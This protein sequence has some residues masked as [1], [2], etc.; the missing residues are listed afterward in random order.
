MRSGQYKVSGVG[1]RSTGT[2]AVINQFRTTHQEL[3][4]TNSGSDYPHMNSLV[5]TMNKMA[6]NRRMR[7]GPIKSVDTKNT[8]ND[9]PDGNE[10]QYD[11]EDTNE[12]DNE[13]SE[14]S[15]IINKIANL[16][17]SQKKILEKHLNKS[18]EN[19]ISPRTAV[20]KVEQR[21]KHLLQRGESSRCGESSRY[22]QDE[23][24]D[25]LEDSPEAWQYGHLVTLPRRQRRSIVSS[26]YS[27]NDTASYVSGSSGYS[28]SSS[29]SY[30]SFKSSSS[31][32]STLIRKKSISES[33]SES[34]CGRGEISPPL[35]SQPYSTLIDNPMYNITSKLSS[36]PYE[37]PSTISNC[38]YPGSPSSLYSTVPEND[39]HDEHIYDIP[40]NEIE[41]PITSRRNISLNCLEESG[42]DMEGSDFDDIHSM[43]D[44]HS[45]EE[46]PVARE[47]R[48]YFERRLEH[49]KNLKKRWSMC[50]S[51]SGAETAEHDDPHPSLSHHSVSAMVNKFENAANFTNEHSINNPQPSLTSENFTSIDSCKKTPLDEKMDFLRKEI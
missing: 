1:S 19:L 47:C 2:D 18:C 42:L 4:D 14:T 36:H 51:D 38:D 8:Q 46:D 28:S 50:S 49:S 39:D 17:P 26:N 13:S 3:G 23:A 32:S 24:N 45:S 16:R 48:E 35:Q 20:T 5:L 27:L 34:C 25:H 21:V 33:L 37:T 6:D 12:M 22:N 10:L 44:L 7:H 41:E 30:G 15:D 9:L 40:N 11:P 31:A 43:D 29:S